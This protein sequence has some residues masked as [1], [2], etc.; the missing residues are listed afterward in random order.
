M[1]LIISDVDGTLLSR[2]E[3][4]YPRDLDLA[5]IECSERSIP[6]VIASGRTLTQLRTIFGKNADRLIFF[7]LDGAYISVG[8]ICAAAFPV[9]TAIIKTIKKALPYGVTGI[10]FCAAEKSYLLTDSQ[11]LRGS[12]ARR[13]GDE[14]ADLCPDDDC[15]EPIYKLIVFTKPGADV[16]FPGLHAVYYGDK[17]KEFVREGIDKAFAASFL[18][19]EL[20][21]DRADVMAFGDSGNDRTLLK[22]AGQPVTIYGSKHEIF[23]LSDK[24]TKNVAEYI[25][26]KLK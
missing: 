6:F 16:S 25:R 18:C 8:N 2:G 26:Y 22:F 15:A 19:N 21:I 24:H 11:E 3:I 20:G 23:A 7:A 9:D 17:V 10:E 4:L 13:L 14:Y 1:K 5:L 12:E